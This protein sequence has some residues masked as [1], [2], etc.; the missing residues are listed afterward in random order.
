MNSYLLEYSRDAEL[1]VLNLPG[2]P[3]TAEFDE[4][5]LHMA[6]VEAMTEGIRRILLVRG[7]GREVITIFS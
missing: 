2:L 6:L 1:V 7:G 5:K 3:S 4:L